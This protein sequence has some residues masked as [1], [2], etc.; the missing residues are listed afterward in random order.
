MVEGYET[1]VE[2]KKTKEELEKTVKAPVAQV[3]QLL[4]DLCAHA[5]SKGRASVCVMNC[6]RRWL[7]MPGSSQDMNRLVKE[8]GLDAPVQNFKKHSIKKEIIRRQLPLDLCHRG[9]APRSRRSSPCSKAATL[10]PPVLLLS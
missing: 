3:Q 7:W 6:L 1:G 5:R 9:S 2:Q 8:E 4:L 10:Y